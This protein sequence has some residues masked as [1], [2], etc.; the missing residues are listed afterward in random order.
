M[1][2]NFY[3]KLF[4][5]LNGTNK[6]KITV[7]VLSLFIL[8]FLI[9]FT[10]NEP[11][12]NNKLE[13]SSNIQ[14][15][16][17]VLIIDFE[18]YP[19]TPQSGNIFTSIFMDVLMELTEDRYIP[20]GRN[21]IN[22]ISQ[23][24]D[25]E[26]ADLVNEYNGIQIGKLAG[27]DAV[28]LGQVTLWE[29]G[30]LFRQAVV[31]YTA[32]CISTET[33]KVLWSSSFSKAIWKNR[34]EQRK[35]EIIAKDVAFIGLSSIKDRFMEAQEEI[36][37]VKDNVTPSYIFEK[38]SDVDKNIPVNTRHYPYRFAL[39]VGNEDYSS[40]QPNLSSEINVDFARNDA[41]AFKEYSQ[42]VL[43]I[44]ET[45]ILFLLDATSGQINQMLGKLN[46]I[47][48]YSQEQSE[49]FFYYAGHGLPDEITKEPYIIPVDVSGK[50]VT[51]G[52]KLADIYT[53]LTEYPCKRV[54]VFLDACFSGGGRSEGLLATRGVKI[55]PKSNQLEGNLI[56][57]SS[58]SEE[59]SS[60]PFK[61]KEHGFFTYYL[62]KKL[63]ESKGD[64]TY[65]DL[66]NY[67]IDNIS[68]QSVLI[69]DK[70]QI[71]QT[72]ISQNLQN[73]WKT[74]KLNE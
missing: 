32:R 20:I 24:I 27:A 5:V 64:I 70:E 30:T 73:E 58:C 15:P 29:K 23:K 71:P 65:E 53:K 68:L 6:I 44:P 11:N 46:L 66:S 52:I 56:V 62:L 43:G 25:L 7:F 69:N 14:N 54:T 33:G 9:S 4:T 28:I 26:Q 48:K 47:A 72:N 59:Q 8:L 17:K 18:D 37:Y 19:G 1:K 3:R 57:F 67:L 10:L 40:Y 42:K 51:L 74:W 61:D 45:N 41:S 22:E 21:K 31:G 55:T 34:L 35:P 38:K 2:I 16:I 39:I 36:L 13:I 50:D 63:Q 49:L 12:T 60:L